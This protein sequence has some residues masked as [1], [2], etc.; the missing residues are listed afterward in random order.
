VIPVIA[1]T[2]APVGALIFQPLLNLRPT[3]WSVPWLLD[4][5]VFYPD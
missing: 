1:I 2:L 5:L 3:C 4:L